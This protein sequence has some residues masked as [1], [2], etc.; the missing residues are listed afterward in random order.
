MNLFKCWAVALVLCAGI[1]VGCQ[2]SP[3]QTAIKVEGVLIV[4]VDA[5]MSEWHDYVVAHL[6]DGKVTQ[7]QI[8][9][10]RDAYNAYYSAQQIA[11][12]ALMKSI[13]TTPNGNQAE[14]DATRAALANAEQALLNLLN[15]YLK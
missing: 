15:Q 6:T 8:D 5:G 11:K 7:K 10:V 12:A 2:T 13:S 4:S 3:T 14:V 1:M 9:S